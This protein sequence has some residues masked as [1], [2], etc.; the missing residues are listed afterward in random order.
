VQCR[1]A[2][3]T[4]DLQRRSCMSGVHELTSPSWLQQMNVPIGGVS[5]M[6]S[7]GSLCGVGLVRAGSWNPTY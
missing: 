7:M 5:T 6:R 1:T 3:T 4:M 2:L